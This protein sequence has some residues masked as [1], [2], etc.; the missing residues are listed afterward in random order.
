M[1]WEN[2]FQYFVAPGVVALIVIAAQYVF[3]PKMEREKTRESELFRHQKSIFLHAIE[4]VDRILN[5]QQLEKLDPE[6]FKGHQPLVNVPTTEEVN[7]VFSQ[8][9]L[10]TY[11][12]DI[13]KGFGHFFGPKIGGDIL[14]KRGEF[15]VSLRKELYKKHTSTPAAKIPF[16]YHRQ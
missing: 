12:E 2:T 6:K 16:Y 1:G 5:A 13:P 9:V 11:D 3:V 8:L 10:L 7:K 14:A 4:I 15:I